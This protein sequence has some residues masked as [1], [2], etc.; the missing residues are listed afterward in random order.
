[1]TRNGVFF[2]TLFS[3]LWN[4]WVSN[5]ASL[6]GLLWK[7]TDLQA[8]WCR[9]DRCV[10]LYPPPLLPTPGI[11]YRTRRLHHPQAGPSTLCHSSCPHSS[12]LPPL[13]PSVSSSNAPHHPSW[14]AAFSTVLCPHFKKIFFWLYTMACRTLVAL[15]GIE[16]VPPVSEGKVLTTRPQGSPSGHKNPAL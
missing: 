14:G 15:P 2:S 6:T 8:S 12:P 7:L 1:M 13:S 11:L 9:K 5:S 4:R 16:P 10:S 3:S